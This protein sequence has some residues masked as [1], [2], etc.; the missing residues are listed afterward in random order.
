MAEVRKLFAAV[1]IALGALASIGASC[2]T[3]PSSPPPPPTPL[4]IDQVSGELVEAG[5][6]AP[7]SSDAVAA[8]L[9]TG[10][11]PWIGCMIEGGTIVDCN[12]PCEH[13]GYVRRPSP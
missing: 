3:T 4:T 8:Q 6:L 10:H 7:G 12:A 5:C 11:S 2:K 1:A 9:A 13:A